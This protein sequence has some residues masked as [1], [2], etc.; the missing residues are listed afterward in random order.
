MLLSYAPSA[1]TYSYILYIRNIPSNCEIGA[2]LLLDRLQGKVNKLDQ[3]RFNINIW[4]T[5]PSSL[6]PDAYPHTNAF[7]N[8]HCGDASLLTIPTALDRSVITWSVKQITLTFYNLHFLSIVYCRWEARRQP[9]HDRYRC[10]CCVL[11][12]CRHL[13]CVVLYNEKK[14]IS[15]AICC[16]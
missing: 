11:R 10:P 6:L 13:Y 8:R 1:V 9:E 15:F 5:T 3:P 12:P 14:V 16:R 7:P 4:A 2:V